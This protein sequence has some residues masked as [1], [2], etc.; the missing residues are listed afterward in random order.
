MIRALAP[1]RR[2]H[3]QTHLFTVQQE[4]PHP[5]RAEGSSTETARPIEFVLKP[6]LI[7]EQKR[8]YLSARAPFGT[9]DLDAC[10]TN[11]N[12]HRAIGLRSRT[13]YS[14]SWPSIRRRSSRVRIGAISA[15]VAQ[16]EFPD[17][18]SKERRVWVVWLE[19][20]CGIEGIPRF[21]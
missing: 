16:C 15:Y 14:T 8:F 9:Q 10:H 11:P 1:R 17:C 6:F 20:E 18:R 21:C 4:R 13:R 7:G 2:L 12:A 3:L 19:P 5:V